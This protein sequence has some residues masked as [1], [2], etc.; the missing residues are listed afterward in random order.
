[1]TRSRLTDATFWYRLF[2]TP[3]VQAIRWRGLRH[4]LLLETVLKPLRLGVEVVE[5]PT[6][7]L[8]RTD[9]RSQNSVATQARYVSTLAADRVRTRSA[10]LRSTG[11]GAG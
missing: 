7:W 1:M 2:P 5:V 4:E 6:F 3:L 10:M 8:P 9:G 11:A